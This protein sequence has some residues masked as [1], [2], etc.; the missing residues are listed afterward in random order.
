M[1]VYEF[2]C[3]KCGHQEDLILFISERDQPQ[4]CK[5]CAIPMERQPSIPRLNLVSGYQTHTHL[6]G[7]KG[8]YYG[9]LARKMPFGKPDPLAYF[10]DREKARDVAK[11]KAD[12]QPGFTYE[13]AS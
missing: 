10:T 2:S 7:G 13:N 12:T 8:E 5:L 4:N 11:K 1:P 6:N 3:Q 9:Q